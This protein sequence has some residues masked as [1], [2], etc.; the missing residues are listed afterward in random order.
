MEHLR[1]KKTVNYSKE[2]S[3]RPIIFSKP[4]AQPLRN[5]FKTVVPGNILERKG[6]VSEKE[7]EM[8]SVR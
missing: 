6:R 3:F 4:D 8:K 2:V 7:N 1:N 5:E